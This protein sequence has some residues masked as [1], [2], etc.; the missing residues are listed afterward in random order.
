MALWI[1]VK[2]VGGFLQLDLRQNQ[3][4]GALNVVALRR[5]D[6]FLRVEQ[7]AVIKCAEVVLLPLVLKDRFG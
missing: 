2:M 6:A 5:A 3:V 7:D 4:V 1:R